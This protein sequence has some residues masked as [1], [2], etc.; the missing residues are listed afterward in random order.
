MVEHYRHGMPLTEG[1]ALE[2]ASYVDVWVRVLAKEMGVS[3][4]TAWDTFF[5]LM[6]KG[7][8][9][10]GTD[11]SLTV[12]HNGVPVAPPISEVPMDMLPDDMLAP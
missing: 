7:E 8:L 11:G 3:Y 4:D 10:L 6:N 2:Y 5:S 9:L 12:A 1:A